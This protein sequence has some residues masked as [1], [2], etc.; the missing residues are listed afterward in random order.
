MRVLLDY[1][2]AACYDTL[3]ELS[4]ELDFPLEVTNL[5]AGDIAIVGERILLI[6]RK[7][8]NDFLSS[9]RNGRLFEQLVKLLSAEGI[10]GRGV[11]RIA[12]LIHGEI[13]GY[14][15]LERDYYAQIYGALMEISF[16]YGV[17]SFFAT[18]DSELKSFLRTAIKRE[19]EGKNDSE[20]KGRWYR[21]RKDLPHKDQRIYLL[22]SIPYIGD[23]LAKNLLDHFGSIAGIANASV[24]ELKEVELIGDKKA[25]LIYEIFHRKEA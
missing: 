20:I 11:S 2:E 9:I 1:R 6:E 7:S 13:F 22:S 3:R 14:L 5:R 21:E 8:P 10:G 24:S 23:K 4:E 25:K 16:V 18:N 17:P 19:A 12:L 15:A